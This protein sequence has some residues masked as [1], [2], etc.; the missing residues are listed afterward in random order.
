MFPDNG[1]RLLNYS[2]RVSMLSNNLNLI[3]IRN[4]DWPNHD[5]I[6]IGKEHRRLA[7]RVIGSIADR[8]PRSRDYIRLL[9]EHQTRLP[10]RSGKLSERIMMNDG[11]A[12]L[13]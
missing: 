5:I 6:G 2:I 7:F 13:S 4:S 11:R 8:P 9:I 3:L 10:S 12:W 1:R